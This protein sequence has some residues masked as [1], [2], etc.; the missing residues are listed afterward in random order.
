MPGSSRYHAPPVSYPLGRCLWAGALLLGL[1][2]LLLVALLAS[3][4]Q[5][6]DVRE[7]L[8]AA[9]S[10]ALGL[11]GWVVVS[12]WAG[13]HWWRSPRGRLVWRD[14][15]WAWWSHGEA[16]PIGLTAIDLSWDAQG[17]LLLRLRSERT[18]PGWVWL[19]RRR[20]AARWDDVRRAVW[21][22]Q[23]STAANS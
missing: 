17:L 19:E 9:R 10:L 18:V 21:A 3:A 14:G 20:D 23:R 12:A 4:G 15:H 16:D 1:C 2:L 8:S 13:W 6:A 5:G 22:A 11:A 7:H